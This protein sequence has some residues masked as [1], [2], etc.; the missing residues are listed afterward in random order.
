MHRYFKIIILTQL[1]TLI[2]VS[3]SQKALSPADISKKFN[4]GKDYIVLIH[5]LWNSS[6][7]MEDFKDFFL[8]KDF[9]VINI[10]YPSTEYPI[11]VLNENYLKPTINSISLQSDQKFTLS[12]TPWVDWCFGII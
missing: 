4:N 10:D 7:Q 6:S 8:E 9:Q 2:T 1:T 11:E 5:D 12:R 3:C